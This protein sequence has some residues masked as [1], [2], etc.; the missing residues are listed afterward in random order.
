MTFPRIASQACSRAIP[1]RKAASILD[2]LENVIKRDNFAD[3][4]YVR[5]MALVKDRWNFADFANNFADFLKAIET[6]LVKDLRN[7]ADFADVS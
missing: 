3:F 5:E 4:H 1:V 2:R 7:F 6:A